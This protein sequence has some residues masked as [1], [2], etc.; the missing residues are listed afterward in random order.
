MLRS[1]MTILFVAAFLAGCAKAPPRTAAD[2]QAVDTAHAE[3]V[4]LAVRK[5]A[6]KQAGLEYLSAYAQARIQ[7][8]KQ[9]RHF[10]AVLEVAAPN[11]LSLRI[12]DDLGQEVA[13]VVADGES[14]YY[15]ENRSGRSQRFVQDDQALRKALHLPLSVDDL[16]DRLLL[17][18][19]DSPIL[20]VERENS[21]AQPPPHWVIRPDDSLRVDAERPQLRLYEAKPSGKAW[22]YRVDYSD[23]SKVEGREFPHRIA[24]SFRK[25][26][27]SLTLQL[28]QVA[29]RPPASRDVDSSFDTKNR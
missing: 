9:G 23:Y 17:R 5:L 2:R 4:G 7:R 12:L 10:D 6:A 3:R 21:A 25:P 19:P 24:W 20:Q 22:S 15:Y 13:Q 27:I 18:L 26:S 8:G 1:L 16:V 14:V 28:Q 29:F 11:R